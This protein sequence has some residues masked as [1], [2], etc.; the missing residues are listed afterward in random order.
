MA[1]WFNEATWSVFAGFAALNLVVLLYTTKTSIGHWLRLHSGRFVRRLSGRSD[2]PWLDWK[3]FTVA[4]AIGFA[5]VAAYGIL[6][7]Q[8]GCHPP[9]VSDPM[10]VLAS[11]KAF[12][13]GADPFQVVDCGGKTPLIPYGAAAVFLDALGSLG[14]LAGIYVV[15]GA[16]AVSILPLTWAVAGPARRCVLLYTATS[17]LFVPLVCSQIDGATN[18]IV[19][20][21]LLFALY[22][23]PR[24]EIL[25]AAVSGFLS[26]ARF[27]NLFPLLG[28]TGVSQRRRFI[29]LGITLASFGIFTSITYLVWGSEF[30]GPVFLYQI[31]RRWF[32]LNLFGIALLWNTLPPALL[33]EAGQAA[34]TI[35]LVIV[36]LWRVRRPLAAAAIILTGICL[37]TSFLSFDFLIWLLPIA[38]IGAR[39]RWWLWGIAGIGSLNY[40]LALNVWAWR[41]GIIWPSAILDGI[42]T[43]LLLGLFVDLWRQELGEK[44]LAPGEDAYLEARQSSWGRSSTLGT[45]HTHDFRGDSGLAIESA[46]PS[47]ERPRSSVSETN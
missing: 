16:V 6:G 34:L 33:I 10:G 45:L 17:V 30:L 15:W 21:T 42:L 4:A 29:T 22:L 40:V 14:G 2:L 19:P 32:S 9:A 3:P 8:Y 28:E 38:L 46:Y 43:A 47:G 41:D 5:A 26:T 12:W 11:G 23:A 35:L 44:H 7:G 39:A 27:P 20:V 37:L 36:V 31:G 24:S 18:A 25:G 13:V 1:E